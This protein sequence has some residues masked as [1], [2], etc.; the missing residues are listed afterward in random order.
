[1]LQLLPEQDG[2]RDEWV[3]VGVRVRQRGGQNRCR[4][5]GHWGQ[6]SVERRLVHGGNRNFCSYRRCTV[7]EHRWLGVS[8]GFGLG[9]RQHDGGY[10][11]KNADLF[12]E[13]G[14]AKTRWCIFTIVTYLV[15]KKS[16]PE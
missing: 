6:I 11:G 4:V 15:R 16:N 7:R 1:M 2:S 5:G 8:F 9:F 14:S 3:V 13:R 12:E 10:D